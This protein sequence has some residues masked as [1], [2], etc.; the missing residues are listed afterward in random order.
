MHVSVEYSVLFRLDSLNCVFRRVL[1]HHMH[2]GQIDKKPVFCNYRVKRKMTAR[3]RLCCAGDGEK[4]IGEGRIDA[5]EYSKK[6][7]KRTVISGR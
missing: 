4:L 7:R 6:V 1:T 3:A 2:G 5:I